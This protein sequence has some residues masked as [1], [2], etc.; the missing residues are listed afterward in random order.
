VRCPHELWMASCLLMRSSRTSR[1][2][3]E[4]WMAS[5]L[6]MRSS[7]TLRCA[8]ELWMASCLLMR[9][10][11]TLRCAHELWMASCLLM[12]SSKR[13][14]TFT[15]RLFGAQCLAKSARARAFTKGSHLGPAAPKAPA[16]FSKSR[17]RPRPARGCKGGHL[18]LG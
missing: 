15:G 5:C 9:S 8:H 2:P 14:S 1:C 6:L 13:L 18:Y 4:L 10:S 12:R 17:R 16:L 3:H 7:R 11:R